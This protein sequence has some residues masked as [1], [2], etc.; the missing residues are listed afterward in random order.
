MGH[1][2]TTIEMPE[3]TFRRAKAYAAVRGLSLK[4]LITDAV[5]D[6]LCP[7]RSGSDSSRPWMSLAGAFQGDP[8]MRK[9]LQRIDEIIE[10]EFSKAE[11]EAWA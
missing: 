7:H 10:R 1:V 9:E 3:K 2:K 4:Q 8:T 11:P 6:K 5:E